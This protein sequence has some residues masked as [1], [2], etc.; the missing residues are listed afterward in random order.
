MSEEPVL[1]VEGLQ[2]SFPLGGKD[3]PIVDGVS[4]ALH[5]GRC[6]ALVGES[7]CGKS[8]TALSLM[9]LI[10]QPGSITGGD[11]FLEGEGLR[12]LSVPQMR[13]LRGKKMGMIFQE[14]MTSLNPVTRVGEQVIEAIRI[15]EK[16]S[17]RAARARVIEIFRQVGIPDAESRVEAF[18]HQLSG[19]LKQRVMIA[20]A[21]VLKPRVLIADEPTT[22][23][24][25]T[26]QAQIIEL[27]RELMTETKTAILLITHDLGVV[28]QI[29][30]DIAV[31]YAGRVIETGSRRRVLKF[32]QHPYT[33]GLLGALPGRAERGQ[34]LHEIAGI[35]PAPVHW[36]GGCRFRPR[37]DRAMEVCAESVPTLLPVGLEGSSEANDLEL[38]GEGN[39]CCACYAVEEPS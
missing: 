8:M 24:D 5:P 23:L 20:M 19:G 13:S 1:K 36:P 25:V 15:H 6:L 33:Q 31:M 4:F 17:K 28:N 2:T 30:D 7:G 27:M 29:A 37:C 39:H 32:P 38:Q 21:L 12:S 10:P 34:R 9:R 22:A 18:P 35:V 11:I 3:V 16:V 14:P 26:I